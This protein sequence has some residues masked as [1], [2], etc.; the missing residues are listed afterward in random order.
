ML[1]HITLGSGHVELDGEVVMYCS[2][3]SLKIDTEWSFKPTV[4][5][6]ESGGAAQNTAYVV[7][8]LSP[9]G[10]LV[11]LN[12]GGTFEC[13]SMSPFILTRLFGHTTALEAPIF[14]NLSLHSPPIFSLKFRGDVRAGTVFVFDSPTTFVKLTSGLNLQSET[15]HMVASVS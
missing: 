7:E 14:S 4:F 5:Q 8:Q 2:N 13:A 11:S 9:E 12:V 10:H 15:T 3:F 1:E 6:E